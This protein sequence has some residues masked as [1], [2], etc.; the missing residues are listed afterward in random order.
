MATYDRAPVVAMQ[1]W[2]AVRDE[3]A[4]DRNDPT[5]TLARFLIRAVVA[6]SNVKSKEITTHR[7]MFVKSL[8]AWNAF[9]AGETTAL[10]YHSGAPIPKISK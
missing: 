8:H 4:P 2:S 9:R 10:N 6:G 3:S 1:F 5:R 7:E